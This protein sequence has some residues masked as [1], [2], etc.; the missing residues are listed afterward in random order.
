MPSTPRPAPRA[1]EARR[2]GPA[3]SP[4]RSRARRAPAPR[5]PRRAA[6]TPG[7]RARSGR[8]QGGGGGSGGA[9]GAGELLELL[10]AGEQR[11]K[12][13]A[14]PPPLLVLIGHAASLTPY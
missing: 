11:A 4:R 2:P 1:L 6:D 7:A 14:R 5:A 10:R 13:R 3:P 12:A 9:W 8:V